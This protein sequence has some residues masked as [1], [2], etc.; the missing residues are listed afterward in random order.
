MTWMKII[1]IEVIPYTLIFMLN[2]CILRNVFD[3]SKFR[4]AYK[5]Q[6]KL[7]NAP[8]QAE[9]GADYEVLKESYYRFQT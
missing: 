3:G 6:Q 9:S 1:I 2:I 7:Q 8:L 5:K 4:E